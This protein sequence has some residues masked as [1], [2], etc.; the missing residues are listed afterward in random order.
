MFMHPRQY[1][2]SSL[3]RK[4]I[5]AS[6]THTHTHQKPTDTSKQ[7]I[8]TRYLGHV[9]GCQP[10]RDQNFLIR[11][12]PDTHFI[13]SHKDDT[14]WCAAGGFPSERTSSRTPHI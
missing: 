10:I 9:A 1:N 2:I 5:H 7:P 3:R 6:N 13:V 11:S 4:S 8:R 12:V 14:C